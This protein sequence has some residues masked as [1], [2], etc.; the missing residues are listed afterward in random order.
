MKI[1]TSERQ[2]GKTT[3]LVRMSHVTGATIVVPNYK[4]VWHTMQL[5]KQYKLEIP[6]PITMTEYI[7]TLAS[8]GLGGTK[9]YLIDEL[10]M[11]LQNM[12][13][14]TATLDVGCI[15]TLKGGMSYGNF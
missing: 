15:D 13:V 12:K 4:M 14:I 10:Q 3:F 11:V 8:G 7:Q 1:Y 2:K 9:E 5:A 6:R